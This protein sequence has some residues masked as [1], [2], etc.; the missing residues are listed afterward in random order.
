LS[1]PHR[2]MAT[3]QSCASAPLY[4]FSEILIPKCPH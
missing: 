3:T 4:F 2:Q 1:S